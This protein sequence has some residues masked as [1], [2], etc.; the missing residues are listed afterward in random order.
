MT[1]HILRCDNALMLITPQLPRNNSLEYERIVACLATRNKFSCQSGIAIDNRDLMTYTDLKDN[2]HH[3]C[4][5]LDR[6]HWSIDT[7]VG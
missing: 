6:C 7:K 4:T 5:R 3:I 2:T 1:L